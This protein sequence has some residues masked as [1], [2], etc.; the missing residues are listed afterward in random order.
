MALNQSAEIIFVA[1]AEDLRSNRSAKVAGETI[2][3]AAH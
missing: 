3:A 2:G 1:L